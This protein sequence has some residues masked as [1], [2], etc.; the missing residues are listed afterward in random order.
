MFKILIV[1]KGSESSENIKSRLLKEGFIINIITQID[2]DIFN[3]N[4][5]Y[6]LI[7]IDLGQ[8][9]TIDCNI[10]RNLKKNKLDC[11]IILLSSNSV[12][13]VKVNI[14]MSGA[15]DYIQ[16]PFGME[17]FVARVKVALRK[18]SLTIENKEIITGL[19]FDAA[20]NLIVKEPQQTIVLTR[21]EFKICYVLARN[22][23]H[24]FSR[25]SLY[26]HIYEI[27]VDTEIRTI[28]EYIYSV[29]KKFKDMHI[30]PIKTIWGRGYKWNYIN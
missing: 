2:N 10:I 16:K 1:N 27:D 8:S 18:N 20:N 23:K 21:N 6:E 7:L 17:E 25:Q 22:H 30:D 19:I 26:E 13:S 3:R 24:I 14:L 11:P 28:T 15:D 9:F 12:E 29:R 5:E 4:H